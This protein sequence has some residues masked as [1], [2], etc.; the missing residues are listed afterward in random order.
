MS[1]SKPEE[2]TKAE[3]EVVADEAAATVRDDARKAVAP[4]AAPKPKA[5]V[6]D[7]LSGLPFQTQQVLRQQKEKA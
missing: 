6:A 3:K 5:A 1:T 2:L 7:D 4:K